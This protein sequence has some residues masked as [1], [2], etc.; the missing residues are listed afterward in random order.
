MRTSGP[1]VIS[2]I[3]P[4]GAG[5]TTHAGRLVSLLA[6]GGRETRYVWMR[7]HHYISLVVLGISRI[8]GRTL[9]W[10]SEA[11]R[12]TQPLLGGS[13]ILR[14]LYCVSFCSDYIF[15]YFFKV[16]LRVLL[17]KTVILD[18]FVVDALVDLQTVTGIPSIE[19]TFFGQVLCSLLKQSPLVVYLRAS[20]QEIL[21]R[22]LEHRR[23][24]FL[25]ERLRCYDRLAVNLGLPVVNTGGPEDEA[26]DQIRT[27][28][29]SHGITR[30]S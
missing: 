22:R 5:K 28:L 25:E 14:T 30:N 3:G 1:I 2:L 9:T 15:A 4:D 27:L 20:M 24:P 7:F 16:R 10:E 17:G 29:R 11:K 26:F 13:R 19:E 6:S 23:D 21:S 8:L 12:F 18:R